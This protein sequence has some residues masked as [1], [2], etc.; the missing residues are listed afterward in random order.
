MCESNPHTLLS[1]SFH[2]AWHLILYP[3]RSTEGA[4]AAV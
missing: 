3:S 2:Q 1:L 4:D